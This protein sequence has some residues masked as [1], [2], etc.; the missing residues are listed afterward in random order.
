MKIAQ[1]THARGR[2]QKMLHVEIS[3]R[4][5]K[6]TRNK[7]VSMPFLYTTLDAKKIFTRK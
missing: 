4:A 5:A 6:I 3:D 1:V 2:L 7:R